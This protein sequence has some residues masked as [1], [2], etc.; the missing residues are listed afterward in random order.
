MVTHVHGAQEV[1]E[2]GVGGAEEDVSEL[3]LLCEDEEGVEED[4]E[5]E[6]VVDE[7]GEF[8][9]FVEEEDD[10]AFFERWFGLCLGV[11]SGRHIL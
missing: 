1:L 3:V 2:E 7:G 8:V 4:F 6:L 5:G 11:E 9:G 10:G